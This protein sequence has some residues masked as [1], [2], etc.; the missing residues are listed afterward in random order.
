MSILFFT[1]V[2]FFN[3][4]FLILLFDL[5]FFFFSSRRRHTR[6]PRDWSS[7]V[8]SSDLH[9]EWIG[10]A[11]LACTLGRGDAVELCLVEP[12]VLLHE[13]AMWAAFKPMPERE[14]HQL[15]IGRASG[16]GGGEAA[17]GRRRCET[18]EAH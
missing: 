9:I 8:C 2:I 15:E 12:F 1:S 11:H 4:L 13:Q 5:L 7:D 17:G 6:W 14:T 10:A 16:R 18:D 3:F